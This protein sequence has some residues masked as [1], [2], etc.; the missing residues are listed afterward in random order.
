MEKSITFYQGTRPN[1][2]GRHSQYVTV[3]DRGIEGLSYI[4]PRSPNVDI[5]LNG[6]IDPAGI[7]PQYEAKIG[8]ALRYA[9]QIINNG[10]KNGSTTL[11][12]VGNGRIT[13]KDLIDVA[14]QVE[15]AMFVDKELRRAA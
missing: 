7:T 4:D 1:R 12:L 8:T 3:S 5:L 9:H 14:D 2:N 15:G 11:R 6:K 13:G 10:S